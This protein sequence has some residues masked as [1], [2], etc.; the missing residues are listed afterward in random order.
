MAQLLERPGASQLVTY[1]I[2]GATPRWLGTLGHVTGLRYSYTCPGGCDQLS[3]TLQI[4]ARERT[5]ALNP[6][7]EVRAVRGASVI[8]RGKLDEPQ[9][10]PAGWSIS[11]HGSGTYG[12]DYA[13]VYTGTWGT[14]TPDNA[15]N[16]AITRGLNWVNPGIGSPAN[17]W[18]G[19]PQNSASLQITDLLNLVCTKGGLTWF[20]ACRPAASVL[21]VFPLPTTVTNLLVSNTPV[22][23][24]LGGDVNTIWIGYQPSTGAFATTSVADANSVA[25]HGT[26]E[27]YVD[28][29]A[30]NVL[31]A[32]AA[33]AVG[34]LVLQR[35]QRASFAGPFTVGPGQ[36][37]TTGGTPVDLGAGM[38]YA[39]MV[40]RLILTDFGYGGEVTPAPIQFLVGGYEFDD[41][42][43][44]ATVT[45][46][47]ALDTSFTGLLSMVVSTAPVRKAV[48]T[49]TKSVA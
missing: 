11:A 32:T 14:G 41:D 46:F 38:P 30:A 2:H 3:A 20:V 6:G 47:Q 17:M 16:A 42:T 12:A 35:Y 5:D 13:A 49:S 24:T 4:S 10:S 26:I 43:Q 28:L 37:L 48:T 31:T 44:T 9:P 39:P 27:T 40:A 34:N 33:Q 1:D 36:L 21:S 19:Q 45:P 25:V 23:R 7:R 29:S 15:V 8:W 18:V 22:A